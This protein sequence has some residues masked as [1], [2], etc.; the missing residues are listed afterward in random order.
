MAYG[1]RDRLHGYGV[2]SRR[3]ARHG[4]RACPAASSTTTNKQQEGQNA[5]AGEAP[6]FSAPALASHEHNAKQRKDAG[7]K[8]RSRGVERRTRR[9]GGSDRHGHIPAIR[10]GREAG[11]IERTTA[12]RGKSRA[13]KGNRIR[14]RSAERR[15]GQRVRCRCPGFH[16][17]TRSRGGKT[18]ITDGQ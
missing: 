3:R 17:I 13:S 7:V 2:G 11:G 5:R 16:R 18:K 1:P 8:R 12:V 10:A 14:K 9:R 15:N 6:A 4:L